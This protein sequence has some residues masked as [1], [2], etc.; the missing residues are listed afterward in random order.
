ME[1][2]NTIRHY[3]P[4]YT[5]LEARQFLQNNPHYKIPTVYDWAEILQKH[6][7]EL[8]DRVL[9]WTSIYSNDGDVCAFSPVDGVHVVDE[10]HKCAIFAMDRK[11]DTLKKE[12]L[13]KKVQDNDIDILV[14]H[15]SFE[16]AESMCRVK[17]SKEWRLLSWSEMEA[18]YTIY[19]ETKFEIADRYYWT[20]SS[21]DED[22]YFCK[23]LSTGNIR[24]VHKEDLVGV[25]FIR[26]KESVKQNDQEE[27]QYMLHQSSEGSFRYNFPP[28][29]TN[30]DIETDT[31]NEQLLDDLKNIVQ[32]IK[33]FVNKL[34]D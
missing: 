4:M 16:E 21:L 32:M 6:R 30:A 11:W 34:G 29:I 27:K 2:D 18:L 28:K 17:P 33:K 31:I 8:D 20:T 7:T 1:N 5:W 26:D 13:Q 10:D 22:C 15:Y 25:I 12:I 24:S 23:N 14:G 19:K 9:Y 3:P